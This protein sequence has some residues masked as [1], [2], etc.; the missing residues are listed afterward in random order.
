MKHFTLFA[1]KKFGRI[2]FKKMLR[3][4]FFG[5]DGYRSHTFFFFVMFLNCFK[6]IHIIF[7]IRKKQ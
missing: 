6:I 7:I 3:E 5:C 2:K 1:N 4:I